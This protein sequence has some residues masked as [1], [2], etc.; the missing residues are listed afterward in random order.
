MN[1]SFLD[2][3][4]ELFNE[5]LL[6]I[7]NGNKFE[8]YVPEIRYSERTST[9]L[10]LSQTCYELYE[11]LLLNDKIILLNCKFS[12][13]LN[14]TIREYFNDNQIIKPKY[15]I[16]NLDLSFNR[17][18]N[19]EDFKLICIDLKGI[20]FL[21]KKLYMNTFSQKTITNQTIHYLFNNENNNQNNNQNR[22]Q[23]NYQNNDD[24]IELEMTSCSL[25][26]SSEIFKKKLFSSRI[27]SL[28]LFGYSNFFNND[29]KYNEKFNPKYLKKLNLNFCDNATDE[30][31]ENLINLK[32]LSIAGCRNITNNAFKKLGK[33]KKLN[34][35]FCN[36]FDEQLFINLNKVAAVTCLSNNLNNSNN[37]EKNLIMLDITGCKKINDSCFKYFKNL[38]VLKM[39]WCNQKE[40]SSKSFQYLSNLIEL[41]MN[42]CN[43]KTIK[44]ED[45]KYLKKLK[46]LSMY[47]CKQIT[48]ESKHFKYLTNL[49]KLNIGGS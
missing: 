18:L 11:R 46:K 5:I 45:F 30:I 3:P 34:I 47:A 20:N 21:L 1:S 28:N 22:D 25:L 31:I 49:K 32:E 13:K 8:D 41:E 42:G 15:L 9:L 17:K 38:R 10:K 26:I 37:F 6:F 43:Q 35:S 2:L 48:I 40:L 44:S 27:E 23:I 29:K 24:L 14:G 39:L 16:S 33:L 19:D 7:K 12:L 36:Q 4:N